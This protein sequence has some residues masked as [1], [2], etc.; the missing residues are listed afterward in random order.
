MAGFLYIYISQGSVATPCRCHLACRL[1]GP[2]IYCVKWVLDP[3]VK[4]RFES[5]IQQLKHAASNCCYHM[6]NR[7]EAIPHIVKLLCWLFCL[8]Q[9]HYGWYVVC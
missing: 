8:L 6:V 3:Q 1:V 7:K 2:T 9:W 5:R 4:G